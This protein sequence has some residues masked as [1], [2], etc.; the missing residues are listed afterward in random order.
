MG[1]ARKI[2]GTIADP[3]L[4]KT[5]VTVGGKTYNLCFTFGALAM[6]EHHINRSLAK[7]GNPERVF[8]LRLLPELTLYNTQILFAAAVRQFHPELEFKEACDLV[9]YS[10]V[11][12]IQKAI[13]DGFSAAMP[14]VDNSADPPAPGK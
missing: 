5:P 8:L 13:V 2:A 10:S 14:E 1:K 6:A 4:P 7:E 11:F 12:A 3:T 9:N